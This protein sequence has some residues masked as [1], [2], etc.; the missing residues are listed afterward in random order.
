MA[1]LTELLYSNETVHYQTKGAWSMYQLLQSLMMD[2]GESIVYLSTYAISETA[3]RMLA[4]MKHEGLLKELHC[5]IDN[6]VETR[7]AKSLQ[8]MMAMADHYKLIACHAKVTLIEGEN[9]SYCVVGSANYT[10]N[11]RIEAGFVSSNPDII[12]MHKTWMLDELSNG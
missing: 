7:T 9:R 5:L 3:M 1:E 10:E 4:N 2:A 12:M 8:L 6:R 11:K